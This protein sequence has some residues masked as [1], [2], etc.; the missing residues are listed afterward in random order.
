METY[1]KSFCVNTMENRTL[2][3]LLLLLL[4]L[5]REWR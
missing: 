5:P 2:L 4:L 1:E 3:L